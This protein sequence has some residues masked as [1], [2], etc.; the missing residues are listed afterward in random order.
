[1]YSLKLE[2]LMLTSHR[3]IKYLPVVVGGEIIWALNEI[4]RKFSQYSEREGSYWP[5]PRR[6][7]ATARS[8]P[9][10]R[11]ISS[12]SPKLTRQK[13][14]IRYFQIFN[15]RQY[16]SFEPNVNTLL[17]YIGVVENNRLKCSMSDV[18]CRTAPLVSRVTCAVSRWPEICRRYKWLVVVVV[19]VADGG[20]RN[21]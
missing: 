15:C 8:A 1:M 19:V 4:S 21:M 18:F 7:E 14:K 20:R 6:A 17:F 11:H 12:S 3:T 2:L 13:I 9:N 16:F 10:H 5:Y